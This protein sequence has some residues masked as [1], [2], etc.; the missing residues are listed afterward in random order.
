MGKLARKRVSRQLELSVYLTVRGW[1]GRVKRE[2]ESGE[3]LAGA[4][5]ERI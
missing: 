2:S 5:W 3:A 4:V 1:K